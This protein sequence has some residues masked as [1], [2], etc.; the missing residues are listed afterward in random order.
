MTATSL[1]AAEPCP[2]AGDEMDTSGAVLQHVLDAIPAS[3]RALARA[4]GVSPK[5][6]RMVRDGERRLTAHTRDAI[7]SALRAWETRCAGAAD[8]LELAETSDRERGEEN[9]G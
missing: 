1:A 2:Q 3:Q 8:A 4:A 7:A 6:L 9:D 5:L